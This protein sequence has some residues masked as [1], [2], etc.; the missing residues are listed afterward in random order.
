M[1]ASLAYPGC[2]ACEGK[3]CAAMICGG[4]GA[5]VY[6]GGLRRSNIP[7]GIRRAVDERGLMNIPSVLLKMVLAGLAR[8]EDKRG[9]MSYG[10]G[11]WETGA[12]TKPLNPARVAVFTVPHPGLDQY[13]GCRPDALP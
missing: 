5:C 12:S 11:H 2:C 1:V 13:F 8:G 9:S 3:Q 4:I 7:A 6:A 10:K